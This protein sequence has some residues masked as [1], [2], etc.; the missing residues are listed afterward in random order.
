MQL[1]LIDML[2]ALQPAAS[3]P[4]AAAPSGGG[5][6]GGPGIVQFLFIPGMLLVMYFLVIRP[7]V[8]AQKERDALIAGLQKGMIVRTDSG[9]RGEITALTDTEATLLIAEK[10]KINILR[11]KIAGPEKAADASKDSTKE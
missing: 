11:S 9:I 10:T 5:A 1:I 6:A 3:A 7:Q 8:K 2:H 4:E